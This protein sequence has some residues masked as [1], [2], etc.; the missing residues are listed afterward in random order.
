MC[1]R[2]RKGGGSSSKAR[3][4]EGGFDVWGGNAAGECIVMYLLKFRPLCLIQNIC[5][6]FPSFPPAVH[7]H[8]CR[9]NKAETINSLTL[10][11]FISLNIH[12]SLFLSPHP[13]KT[14]S[15]FLPF[16]PFSFLI[17][18]F[19]QCND[20]IHHGLLTWLHPPHCRHIKS[21]N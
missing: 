20:T 5:T 19:Q 7:S 12:I 16:S 13:N 10:S 15:L 17:F 18:F 11:A 6:P 1:A 3:K 4:V 9:H 21:F 8:V 14:L 2:R